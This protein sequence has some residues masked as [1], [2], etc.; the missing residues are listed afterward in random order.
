MMGSRDGS[1]ERFEYIRGIFF[2]STVSL[3]I[4]SRSFCDPVSRNTRLPESFSLQK[5]NIDERAKRTSICL[6]IWLRETQSPQDSKLSEA[7]NL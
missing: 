5:R 7:D 1:G 2:S 6:R 3:R 4:P